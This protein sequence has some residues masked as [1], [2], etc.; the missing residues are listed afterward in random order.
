MRFHVIRML[1]FVVSVAMFALVGGVG[2]ATAQ[3]QPG[4]GK[5][6]RRLTGTGT[7]AD[8]TKFNGH[9]HGNCPSRK[10]RRISDRPLLV[11]GQWRDF[12][13]TGAALTGQAT[14]KLIAPG[15]PGRGTA[16]GAIMRRRCNL[17]GFACPSP[18][19]VFWGSGRREPGSCVTS[20]T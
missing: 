12:V 16:A 7:S 15:Q 5:K 3:P 6:N 9:V 13:Q 4:V 11:T 10:R 19:N 2:T 1:A 18:D 17:S 8:G 14:G 20:S